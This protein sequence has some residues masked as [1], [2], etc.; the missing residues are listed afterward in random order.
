MALQW[1]RLLVASGARLCPW[2]CGD[3]LG[4][5]GCW[6]PC[7]LL[8]SPRTAGLP[9]TFSCSSWQQLAAPSCCSSAS[10][11][12]ASFVTVSFKRSDLLRRVTWRLCQQLLVLAQLCCRSTAAS[13][14]CVI[15]VLGSPTLSPQRTGTEEQWGTG[16]SV[17]SCCAA[18]EGRCWGWGGWG[19]GLLPYI[20]LH[21][22]TWP[23]CVKR[24][25]EAANGAQMLPPAP[26]R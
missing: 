9:V 19:R 24:P 8:G 7:H 14:A 5:G 3:S 4:L 21:I 20:T 12:G 22:S 16:V 13:P 15:L 6:G 1:D 25:P 17:G 11:R 10:R 18:T 23:H 26:P 2:H